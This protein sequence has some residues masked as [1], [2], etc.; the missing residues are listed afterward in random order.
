MIRP[1]MQPGMWCGRLDFHG[2][3]DFLPLVMAAHSRALCVPI[4]KTEVFRAAMP[5]KTHQNQLNWSISHGDIRLFFCVP[6]ATKSRGWK[7]WLSQ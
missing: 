5:T 7:E 1:A 2:S 4:V 6:C 3:C